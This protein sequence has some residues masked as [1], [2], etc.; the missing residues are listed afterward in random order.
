MNGGDKRIIAHPFPP[1]YRASGVLLPVTSLPSRHGIGDFGPSASAWIDRLSEAKQSWWQAL[2]LGPTGYGN[3]PYS[4]LSSFAGNE[5]LISP[6]RLIEDGLLRAIDCEDS[7]PAGAAIDYPA[8]FTFKRRLLE[9]AWTNFSGGARPDLRASLGQFCHEQRYWLEDY[10]LFRAL[11]AR[12]EGASYLDWPLELVKRTP[13]ALNAARR[14]LTSHIEKVCFAQFLLFRQG[15]RVKEHARSRGIGLIG[16]LPF[17]VSLDS[18]DVWANPELF[19]L[20]EQRRPTFVAGVPPDYFSAE[21]QLWGNPVYDWNA[22]R[23]TGYEWWLERLRALL[24]HVE[25]VRLDHF[26]AFAAAWHVPA[27]ATTARQGDWVPGPG[28][29]FFSKVAEALGGLP[30]IA[31]DLGL[32]TPDVGALRDQFKLPGMRVLQFAFDGNSDNPHLPHNFVPNTVV[33]TGTHDNATTRGW[34]EELPW[35]QRQCLWNYLKRPSGGESHEAALALIA[36]AWSSAAALAIAPLQDIL[37]LGS[38]ARM[39]LPGHAEG[40]WGWQSTEEMLTPEA[41][42]WLHDLT[43]TSNRAP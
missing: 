4:S 22:H 15:S 20:D 36:L 29:E 43:Q 30:F 13:E 34:Y 10:A 37:N 5:L 16:D 42:R 32:I 39:N 1:E 14:E 26:R 19:L 28:A 33:Y 21:G 2:P 8:V 35:H 41:F 6:D 23:R 17:F 7:A 31:E 40:N 12:Y 27:E 24:S 3:S 11:K 25:V 9:A 38:E 18:S